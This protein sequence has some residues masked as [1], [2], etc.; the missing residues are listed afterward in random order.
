MTWQVLASPNAQRSI[1]IK[2]WDGTNVFDEAREHD[3]YIGF[4][5]ST[6]GSA[7]FTLG[8]TQTVKLSASCSA[9]TV[10]VLRNGGQSANNMPTK[11]CWLKIA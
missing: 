2:L 10:T 6:A 1:F 9:T 7:V 11:M 8:S 5:Y 3:G 4:R